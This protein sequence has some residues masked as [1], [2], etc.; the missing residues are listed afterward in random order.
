[1]PPVTTGTVD[2]IGATGF[3]GTSKLAFAASTDVAPPSR[4]VPVYQ[5]DEIVWSASVPRDLFAALA[6]G[7]RYE[8]ARGG[9]RADGVGPEGLGAGEAVQR[10]QDGRRRPG[11]QGR[12][13]PP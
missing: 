7:D 11:G 8:G 2:K 3:A 13:A 9:G 6:V 5:L 1:Q 12:P 10:V 4:V